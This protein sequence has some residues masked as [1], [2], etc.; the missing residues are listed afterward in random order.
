MG[1]LTSFISGELRPDLSTG[2]FASEPDLSEEDLAALRAELA[3]QA[4]DAAAAKSD[5]DAPWA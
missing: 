4:A 2:A 3:Q 5:F 1:A